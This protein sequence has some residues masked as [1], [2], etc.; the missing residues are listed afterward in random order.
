MLHKRLLLT[1]AQTEVE[2]E[3][4]EDSPARIAMREA[5]DTISEIGNPAF[6]F[7]GEKSNGLWVAFTDEDAVHQY[8]ALATQ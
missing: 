7:L 8:D 4:W 1:Q 5:T 2:H 3:F 6:F